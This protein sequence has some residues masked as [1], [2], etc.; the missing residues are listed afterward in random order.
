MLPQA[1]SWTSVSALALPLTGHG[2][3]F[4]IVLP[5][6]LGFLT[7]DVKEVGRTFQTNLY[8]R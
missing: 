8:V 4:N 5:P 2:A 1:G 7:F 6:S 3:W